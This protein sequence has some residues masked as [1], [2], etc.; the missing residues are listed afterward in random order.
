MRVF[1]SSTVY[2]LI[3]VRAELAS[4]LRSIGITPVLSDDKLS[5]FKVQPDVNSI[6]TCLVNVASCDEMIVILDRRYGPSLDQCGYGDFSAT[7]LEY[8][9]AKNKNLPIHFYLRDRLDADYSIWKRNDRLDSV[10]LSWVSSKDYGLFR[11]IDEHASL[12]A[13]TKTSNWYSAFSNSIDLKEAITKHFEPRILPARL[14]EA[15]QNNGFPIFDIKL[16]VSP[17]G[18]P[19]NTTFKFSATLT[20][21]GGTPAFNCNIAWEKGAKKSRRMIISPGAFTL[22]THLVPIQ[23]MYKGTKRYIIVQYE[24]PIGILVVDRF[25]IQGRF[26]DQTAYISNGALIE[27]KYFRSNPTLLQ[28]EEYLT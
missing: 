28:I 16:E 9:H 3:D 1:I 17:L 8:Q 20:N 27:R 5:D 4:H 12:N 2:D 22:M 7:H 10:K 15:I 21:I 23:E 6:E 25:C 26:A 24:S 11:L 14:L 18:A 13:D 19:N